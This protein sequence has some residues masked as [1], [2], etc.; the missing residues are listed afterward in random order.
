MGRKP[1]LAQIIGRAGEAGHLR[2]GGDGEHSRYLTIGEIAIFTQDQHFAQRL[3]EC[4]HEPAQTLRAVGAQR[5]LFGV[6]G[7]VGQ[8]RKPIIISGER[9]G[10]G[11]GAVEVKVTS[12]TTNDEEPARGLIRVG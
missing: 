7:G 3:R 1:G 10:G 2:A 5:G 4:R 6:R 11:S 9:G 8:L 12:P